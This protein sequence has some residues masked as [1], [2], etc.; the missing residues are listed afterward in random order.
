MAQALDRA[1]RREAKCRL[2]LECV[3]FV[4][5]G[6]TR[7]PARGRPGPNSR[8]GRGRLV[9]DAK[10]KE[11]PRRAKAA[12]GVEMVYEQEDE[13]DHDHDEMT[14]ERISLFKIRFVIFQIFKISFIGPK[15]RKRNF[16]KS[17]LM[18]CPCVEYKV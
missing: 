7:R 10:N 4:Q 9:K 8:I 5:R 12:G 3:Q 11:H 16:L 14:D 6:S 2:H 18:L 1:A 15:F 13:N 17:G